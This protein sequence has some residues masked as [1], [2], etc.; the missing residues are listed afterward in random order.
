VDGLVGRAG[1]RS[2]SGG[3]LPGIPPEVAAE[4]A[5]P[6]PARR[7]LGLLLRACGLALLAAVLW[8]V[9]WRDRVHL[10]DGTILRGRLVEV[11]AEAVRLLPADGGPER[12]V[13]A[14]DFARRERGLPA[15]EEG[16]LTLARRLQP[17]PTLAV[18]AYILGSAVVAAARWGLLLRTQGLPVGLR[19][20]TALT[21][22]GNFFNQVL[23]GGLVGGDVLKALYAA[24]G[25]ERAPLAV[26]SVFV[27]RVLGLFGTVILAC[28]ALLPRWSD[29]DFHGHA[30]VAYG[31]LVAGLLGG[32]AVLS[33]RVRALLRM[34]AW[35]PRVPFV[36]SFL[37]EVDQA[38]LAF[39]ERKS[40]IVAG[41]GISVAIHAGWCGANFL[42]GRMLGVDLPLSAWFAVIPP[43][44][45]VSS[46]PLLPGG[47]G[48]GE[49]SFVF[50]LGL[51]GVPAAPALAISLLGRSLQILGALPGGFVFLARRA[52]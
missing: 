2:L 17:L 7:L 43:I 11:S 6:S 10:F 47:W 21:F 31:I 34:E 16:V 41:L 12:V 22:L 25:R 4:V 38:V 8:Q 27:D 14:G 30:V 44:L 28:I 3:E 1:G 26:V 19:E 37:A 46:I 15:A 24:R 35:M 48:V 20:A 51:V 29:P 39:R 40:V 13:A 50:F 9:P 5:P 45:I 23:P 32:G 42:L 18:M 36:G 33:R 52:G 49:L